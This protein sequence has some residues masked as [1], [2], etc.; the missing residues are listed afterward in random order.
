MSE[1]HRYF[2]FSLST[3][4]WSDR[5]THA[6]VGKCSLDGHGITTVLNGSRYSIIMFTLDRAKQELYWINGSRSCYLERSNTDGSNRSVVYNTTYSTGGCNNY[7]FMNT[8]LVMDYSEGVV[9]TTTSYYSSSRYVYQTT[10]GQRP[11]LTA[12]YI[13]YLC[14]FNFR[15]MKVISRQRQLQS[16]SQ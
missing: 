10:T 3:L 12:L 13:S 2:D 5:G 9:Y 7:Y 1:S 15:G 11:S 4:Y 8:P 14:S 16:K 6:K